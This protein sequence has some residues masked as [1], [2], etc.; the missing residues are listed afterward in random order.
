VALCDGVALGLP[1]LWQL[2]WK[3][4]FKGKGIQTD[5]LE[6]KSQ[7]GLRLTFLNGGCEHVSAPGLCYTT[8]NVGT[9]SIQVPK[10]TTHTLNY[11]VLLLEPKHTK[12]KFIRKWSRVNT[13]CLC[14]WWYFGTKSLQSVGGR[15][16]HWWIIFP[17]SSPKGHC[18]AGVPLVTPGNTIRIM[19]PDVERSINR[20]QPL[21]NGSCL[22]RGEEEPHELSMS[23]DNTT[24]SP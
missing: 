12:P 10:K 20:L 7:P 8:Y 23:T 6:G 21:R 24:L 1:S 2:Q 22:T 18:K 13:F 11:S 14:M 3:K 15:R 4:C 17:T 19:Y 16:E 5:L 9:G